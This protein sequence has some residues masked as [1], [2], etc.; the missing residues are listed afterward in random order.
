MRGYKKNIL[1]RP[2]GRFWTGFLCPR[3][4]KKDGVLNVAVH[5]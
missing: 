1:T 2:G 3:I 5:R 4:G